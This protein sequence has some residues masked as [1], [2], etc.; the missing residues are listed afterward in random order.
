M[1]EIG[2]LH[3]F[4]IL[5]INTLLHE[6][7]LPV[8]VLPT[9][10]VLGAH[11]VHDPADFVLLVIA[12]AIGMLVGNS[13]WFIAGR[14]Y[15]NRVLSFLCRFSLT[16]DT[17]VSRT[18]K[19]FGRWGAWSLVIGRFL[20]GVSLVAAPIAGAVGMSWRKFAALTLAGA[21]VYG[22]A[23]LGAGLLFRHQIATVMR[24][25]QALG[26]QSLAIA[27]VVVAAY[28]AWRWWR[29]RVGLAPD[30]VRVSVDEL[31]GMIAGDQ[32]PIIVDVRGATTQ[33]IDPRRIPDAITVTLDTIEHDRDSLPRDRK[34]VLYC[35]CPNE[36]TAAK[37]ARLL[38][39]RGYTWVRPLSGGLDAWN[40]AAKIPPRAEPIPQRA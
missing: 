20:P 40:A 34:I 32:K 12:I 23:V 6:A 11:A 9:A 39:A 35:A 36:A 17:C 10:L 3:A 21:V 14:R 38:L 19:S 27:L 25:L 33:T 2:I 26:W 7:G 4:W 8:P 28:L 15:G 30:L 37:A 16:A 18:E 1:S 29:R 31:K 24:A 22:V 5:A 13:V